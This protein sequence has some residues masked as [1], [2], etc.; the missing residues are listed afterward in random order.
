MHLFMLFDVL[1]SVIWMKKVFFCY[2]TC[3]WS[4]MSCWMGLCGYFDAVDCNEVE[5]IFGLH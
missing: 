4:G 2:F 1:S 3:D 5:I